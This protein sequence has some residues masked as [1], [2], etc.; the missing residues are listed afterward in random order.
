MLFLKDTVSALITYKASEKFPPC[1]QTV[2]NLQDL[3]N[4]RTKSALTSEKADL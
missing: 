4:I 2:L 3:I 1:T